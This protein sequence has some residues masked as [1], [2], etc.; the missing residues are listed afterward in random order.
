LRANANL[1]ADALRATV[2]A[3]PARSNACGCGDALQHAII[4]PKDAIDREARARLGVL[5]DRYLPPAG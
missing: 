2:L 4:T 5:L 1:A 3:L